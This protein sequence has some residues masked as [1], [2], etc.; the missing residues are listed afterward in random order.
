MHNLPAGAVGAA[1]VPVQVAS[2]SFAAE[3]GAK[4]T[5]LLVSATGAT[6]GSDCRMTNDVSVSSVSSSWKLPR[7]VTPLGMTSEGE[8]PRGPVTE[9][10]AGPGAPAGPVAPRSAV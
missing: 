8:K 2:S 1:A 7:T 10:P 6:A 9:A 4:L 3:S 5:V